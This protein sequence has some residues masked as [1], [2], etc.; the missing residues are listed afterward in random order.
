MRSLNKTSIHP[1]VASFGQCKR[2]NHTG[3]ALCFLALA[4]VTP[5]ADAAVIGYHD[6][7]DPVKT[8]GWVCQTD[9]A[10]PVR[11]QLFADT[12]SGR[13]LLD[14]QVADKRRDDLA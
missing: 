4:A 13:K 9:A 12:A 2:R 5:A 11:V 1:G 7:S 10:A 14:T 6:L 3:L 8:L